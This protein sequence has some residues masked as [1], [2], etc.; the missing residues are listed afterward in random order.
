MAPETENEQERFHEHGM[1]LQ[2]A[3]LLNTCM[4]HEVI[5]RLFLTA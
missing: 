1:L 4:N 2:L 3:L 5:Q